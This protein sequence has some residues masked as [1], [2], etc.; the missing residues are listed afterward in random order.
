MSNRIL[1]HTKINFTKEKELVIIV[2]CF[3]IKLNEKVILTK[4]Y[5]INIIPFD[6]I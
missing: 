3:V 2:N 6:I 5:H 1:F 4:L